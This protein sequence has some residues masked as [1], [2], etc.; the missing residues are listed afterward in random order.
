MQGTAYVLLLCM[1]IQGRT[2]VVG[3]L[4]HE[5]HMAPHSNQIMAHV[6]RRGTGTKTFIV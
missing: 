5:R 3:Y 6:Y 1:A 4:S 2:D